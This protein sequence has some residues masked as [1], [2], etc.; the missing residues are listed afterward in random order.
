MMANATD[1]NILHPKEPTASFSYAKPESDQASTEQPPLSEVGPRA[2]STPAI[3][4]LFKGKDREWEA[5]RSKA[6]PLRLL[7]LPVDVLRLIVRE[8]TST[9]DQIAL[10]LTNSKL[11][12]L[13]IPHLYT[14]FDI[15]WPDASV[16]AISSKSVDALSYGLSTLC[17]GSK[18][19]Q[20]RK[21]LRSTT[22]G[23]SDSSPRLVDNQYAKYTRKFSI[24]NGPAEWTSEY[25]ISYKESGK[26]LWTL[27]ALAVAKMVNLETFSVDMPT[28]VLSDVF[29][30][31]ASLQ[32]HYVDRKPKFERLWIRWHDNTD[33]GSATSSTASS[34][35]QH[36][37]PPP[38]PLS[39][40]GSVLTAVGNILPPDIQ[41]MRTQAIKYFE[42]RVEYP[43]FSVLPSLKSLT[44]LDIDELAYLDEM[45]ILIE[46]SCSMLEEL[47]VGISQ[48]AHRHD[49]AR[50]WDGRE[51]RQ[52]D[53][54][55]QWPGESRIGDKRLGGVLGVLVGRIYDIR[56]RLPGQSQ[57]SEEYNA[58]LET[59]VSSLDIGPNVHPAF[60]ASDAV[61]RPASNQVP[62]SAKNPLNGK[63]RL[64]VL[65]LE[66]VAVSTHVC[67]KALDW[68]VLTELTLLDCDYH[69]NL[70]K[71]LRHQYANRGTSNRYHLALKYIHTDT[72]STSLISFI[73]E[74]LA[75]N[76]LEVFFL[77]DRRPAGDPSIT[78]DQIFKGIIKR[79]R[80]SLRKLLVNS[81]L[82]PSSLGRPPRDWRV[83]S[84]M[85][86]YITSGRMCNLQELAVCIDYQDWHR[87]LQRLPQISQLRSL[88]IPHIFETGSETE[89]KELALQ[90]VDII[91]I[92]PEIQ[93]CY[94]GLKNKCFEILES[95]PNDHT[96]GQ[97]VNGQPHGMVDDTEDEEDGASD[98]DE[99]TEDDDGND[100]MIGGDDDLTE[101][102]DEAESEAD[103]FQEGLDEAGPSY[104][105][106]REILF[107]DDKVAIFKARHGKL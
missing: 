34:P 4:K 36:P 9:N 76:S 95:R 14:R 29:L 65:A 26:M 57:Q 19:T 41:P 78:I 71:A 49:F 80:S 44:V 21:W 93:L 39:H 8:V 83:S 48:K 87:F 53:L 6:G 97:E 85:I 18:F 107:Y 3:T 43:T 5:I 35:I 69:E 82:R 62:F 1:S 56:K 51:L 102:S 24:G 106:L 79:H 22:F 88:H 66:R 28:G 77:Q 63:L 61:A 99:G 37:V 67:T 104:L 52:V 10:A 40:G 81:V 38:V 25:R 75:P 60:S 90:I 20:T 55:A 59:S 86:E 92:R 70:W 15:V 72:A 7:D 33:T 12:N 98:G 45:S 89:P 32:D 2:Q 100:D 16:P 101:V 42:S 74:A 47:R 11:Y 17:L 30:A 84:D 103:S 105:W 96:H 91:T 31:L 73:K 27:V 23:H 13:A 58:A 94:I 46:R 68:S 54:D 64:R 50:P